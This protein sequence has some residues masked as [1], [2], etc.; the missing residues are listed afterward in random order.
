M[1]FNQIMAV[2]ILSHTILKTII[3]KIPAWYAKYSNGKGKLTIFLYF[4]GIFTLQ[5]KTNKKPKQT[6]SPEHLHI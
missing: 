5:E 3:L 1:I 2:Q 4:F 6:I